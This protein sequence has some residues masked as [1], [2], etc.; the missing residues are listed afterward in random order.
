MH[1][2]DKQKTYFNTDVTKPYAF[3]MKQLDHLYQ[4]IKKY[5][6]D[7]TEALYK[8]L[9]KSKF[10]A[11]TSEIGFCL[12]SIRTTQKH[13]KKWMK[14]KKVK[15]P[16]YQFGSKSYSQRDPLGTVLIIGPYNYPFQLV[17]EPLIGAIAAG[18]TAIIKPSEFTVHT[19]TVLKTMIEDTFDAQYIAVRTGDKDVTSDLLKYRY[20]HVFFT[21]STRVGQIV[22]QAAAKTLSPVTL[23]LGG[24]S[25]TI[26]T[27]NANLTIAAKRI[28]FGKFINAGQTCIAPDYLY[29]D[30]TI[31]DDFI[32]ILKKT[33]NTFYP[34]FDDDYARIVN[35]THFKRIMGLIDENKVVMDYDTDATTRLISPVVMDDVSFDDP[36]MQEEIFGP[37]LP[38]MTY[39]TIEDVIH[40]LKEQS[41]PLALYIFSN[42]KDEI[43]AVFT[44]LPFGT[45]GI[46]ATL[47]QVVNPYLPF[48]GVGNSGIGSYHGKASFDT[49]T[50]QKTYVKR[51][52][53]FDPAIAYPPYAGKLKWIKKILK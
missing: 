41:K 9:G 1:I 8:D 6:R 7:F 28:V 39:D 45:G 32:A 50:N 52:T 53:R 15:R 44:R 14:R 20:D 17:V 34:N 30:K 21:G 51:S 11:Y 13:L 49:F 23:E 26:I 43:D 12:K 22:Y 42:N 5:E 10:E 36:V 16:L 48:G 47:D 25:P 2:T 3:R 33:I 27:K 4:S 35:D 19:E 18:N 38:I 37:I 46:N 31:K 29:I 40:T 24:K